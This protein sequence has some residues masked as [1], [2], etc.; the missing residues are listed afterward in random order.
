MILSRPIVATYLSLT[1]L[2]AAGRI[3]GQR[4]HTLQAAF[5]FQ[6]IGTQQHNHQ[7]LLDAHRHNANSEE[8]GICRAGLRKVSDG[9]RCTTRR[10][11]M[12]DRDGRMAMRVASLFV[13][14]RMLFRQAGLHRSTKRNVGSKREPD[15]RTQYGKL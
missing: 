7:H 13:S 4:M 10:G 12:H 2:S 15:R 14:S 8:L 9:R 11:V 3:P 5:R 6:P 1:L